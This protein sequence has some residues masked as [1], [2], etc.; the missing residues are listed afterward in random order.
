MEPTI[1]GRGSAENPANRFESTRFERDPESLDPDDPEPSPLTVLIPD[2]TRTIIATN[3][4]PDVGFDASINPYRG[5]EHGCAYCYARPGHEYLGLSAGLDFE[6]KIHVKY[7]AP[8][9]LRRELM[10]PAWVPKVIAMSGVTDAYQPAERKLKITRGCLEVLAEFRNPVA[11]I[12]KNRLVARDADIL[13]DMAK[14]NAAGVFVSVT[15]LDADLARSLE[16]RAS[17]PTA[18][19]EAIAA[20]AKAGVPVG[21]AVAP[22]IP[23]LTDHEMPAIL[24]A[25]AAAGARTAFYTMLRLPLGVA[26]LFSEWLDRHAP[27]AK[28]KVLGRL[29]GMRDGR[30]NDARFGHRMG[31]DGA[32]ADLIRTVFRTS[33]ARVGLDRPFP[34]LSTAGFRRPGQ[35]QLSLFD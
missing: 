29:R 17:T 26:D 8:G 19:L 34:E 13:S 1:K 32:H 31:G 20:L 33:V 23:G 11:I 15:S 30:L 9:L 16:P 18:R 5:C 28:E 3:D 35:V 2:R 7:D 12:T 24:K 25:A 4:S 6:T 14:D 22:V 10:K 21:V 27:L